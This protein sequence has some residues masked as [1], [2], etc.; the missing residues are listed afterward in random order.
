VKVVCS[1]TKKM[2]RNQM[3]ERLIEIIVFLLGELS[4][5]E[6]IKHYPDLSKELISQGYSEN[7]INL[8]YSWIFN[9]LQAEKDKTKE[10]FEYT[11]DSDRLLH[12]LE[13]II[14]SSE[15][16]GYLL[17][18][19]HLNLLSD[20]DLEMVIEKAISLGTSNVSLDDIKSIAASLIFNS[21]S[22]YN[23]EGYFYHKGSNTIH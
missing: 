23:F 1:A 10:A 3:Q 15:A 6:D 12:D 20:F 13:K 8:A 5:G 14:I 11:G 18:M 17:Q 4:R 22:N 19:R 2:M 9:H 7:E 21:D 16:Y